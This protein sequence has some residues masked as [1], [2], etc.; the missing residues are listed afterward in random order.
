MSKKKSG[1]TLTQHRNRSGPRLGLKIGEGQKIKVGQILVRQRGTVLKAGEGVG[2]GR[3][4]SLY[5]LKEGKVAFK[6]LAGR[7][8]VNIV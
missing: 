6:S 8:F 5:A 1:S 7:Q 4:N 2:V 3:D